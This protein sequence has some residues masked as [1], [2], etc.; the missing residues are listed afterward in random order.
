VPIS[1]AIPGSALHLPPLPANAKAPAP[2]APAAGAT[3]PAAAAAP[4]TQDRRT[5]AIDLLGVVIDEQGRNI[6]Q[7]RDTV[8]VT[9]AQLQTLGDKNVQYQS[10]VPDIPA[11]HYKV[12]V[13]VRE[14]TDGMLGTFEFPISIPDLKTAPLKVS[15]VVFSTQLQSMRGGGPGGRGGFGGGPGGGRGGPGGPGGGRGGFG[16]P[17]G[18]G[19]GGAPFASQ[20]G[21]N[22]GAFAQPNPLIRGGEEILQSLTHV[23]TT[24]QSMYFYYEVY[25]PA[26]EQPSGAP[27]LRTS[28]AFYRGRVKVFETPAVDHTVVDDTE[29]H[30]AVFQF[31]LP[32]SGLKPGLYTCQV[33]II[34]EVSGKFAFPRLALYVKDATKN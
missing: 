14:N 4:A 16:G 10:G 23:V 2:P 11:G 27:Q 25:D 29:R 26:V 21:G 33:N 6:G 5:T 8:Q 13:A 28:L 9:A 20:R 22:G 17:G 3:A 1:I 12:K 32:A 19:F 30:A 7:I 31:Q 24:A 18:G 15:P 34:D